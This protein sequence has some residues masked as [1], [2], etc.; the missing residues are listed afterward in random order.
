M[1]FTVSTYLIL[2]SSKY[3]SLNTPVTVPPSL[4]PL[5]FFNI[6]VVITNSIALFSNTS[7]V[8]ISSGTTISFVLSLI[9]Y[10]SGALISLTS[11]VPYSFV[12]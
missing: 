8:S 2:F 1:S 10:P 6:S 12:S 7:G 3:S 9:I 5:S 4:S 11:Y